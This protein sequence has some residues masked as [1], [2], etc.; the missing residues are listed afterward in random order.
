MH[1]ALARAHFQGKMC[2]S[3]RRERISCIR[4][5]VNSPTA[6]ES[7]DFEFKRQPLD[8][9]LDAKIA[10]RLGESTFWVGL[11][12]SRGAKRAFRLGEGAFSRQKVHF[13]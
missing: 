9:R 2:I 8:D 3:P 13:A 12:C 11:R 7:V 5:G 10:F 1:F 4:E 6:L